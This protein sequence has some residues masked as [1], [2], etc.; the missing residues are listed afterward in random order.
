[1]TERS[2][3]DHAEQVFIEALLR[4]EHQDRVD[5]ARKEA[6]PIMTDFEKQIAQNLEEDWGRPAKN[7]EY[8]IGDLLRYRKDGS[9]WS[10]EIVWIAA[11]SDSTVEGHEP[12]PMRYIV[13]R[14][15][16]N[17]SIPDV[18]YSRDILTGEAQEPSL[19]RCPYCLNLHNVG[20]S[21]YCP[22]RPVR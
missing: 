4:D 10:G 6:E 13:E 1:M 19:E 11:Q 5:L 22:R 2:D 15:G 8:S 12:L 9:T 20:T 3:R 18:V 14:H 16:W 7:A 17:D 21:Q